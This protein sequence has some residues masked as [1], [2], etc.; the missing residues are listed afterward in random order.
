MT[1]PKWFLLRHFFARHWKSFLL[2]V[3]IAFLVI[4]LAFA[5]TLW[6][7]IEIE[8]GSDKDPQRYTVHFDGIDYQDLERDFHG[9]SRSRSEYKTK[10]G[11]RIEFHGNFYEVEQ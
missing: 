4:V 2:E 10:A 11:K 7:A 3:A 1:N 8:Q 9:L 5:V 6:I